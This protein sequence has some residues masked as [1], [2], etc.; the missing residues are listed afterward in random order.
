MPP[1]RWLTFNGLHGFISQ[2]IV[3][4]R[5][6]NPTQPN[7]SLH[8]KSAMEGRILN[9]VH[10]TILICYCHSQIFELCH[11]F[12]GCVNYFYH[13]LDLHSGD[14]RATYT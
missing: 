5:I 2:K 1:K 12:K 8:Q 9:F 13:D 14:E 7:L 4:F 3:L 10:E 6:S 11:I